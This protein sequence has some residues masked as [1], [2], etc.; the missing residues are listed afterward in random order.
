MQKKVSTPPLKFSLES[1]SFK[2]KIA[3]FTLNSF[4]NHF[5]N[6]RLMNKDQREIRKKNLQHYFWLCECWYRDVILIQSEVTQEAASNPTAVV[7]NVPS[8]FNR[9]LN[10]CKIL[11]ASSQETQ[12][13]YSTDSDGFIS[14]ERLELS[15]NIH[16]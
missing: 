11:W 2:F 14:G 9:W 1:S 4:T 7:E 15:E 10:C 8:W 6:L 3:Y 16:N 13:K 12:K 5:L